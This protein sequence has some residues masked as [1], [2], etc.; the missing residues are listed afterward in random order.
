MSVEYTNVFA[1]LEKQ[2]AISGQRQGDNA[3]GESKFRWGCILAHAARS[4]RR[5]R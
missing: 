2:L 1:S 4:P 5:F 3:E